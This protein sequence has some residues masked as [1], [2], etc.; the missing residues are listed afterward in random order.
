MRQLAWLGFTPCSNFYSTATL[1][2][3]VS[4]NDLNVICDRYWG[5]NLVLLRF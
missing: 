4:K 1:N 3:S 5:M 2:G